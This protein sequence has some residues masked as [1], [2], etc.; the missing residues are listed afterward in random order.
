MYN[1]DMAT[2]RF[3]HFS[4]NIVHFKKCFLFS[5]HA[6]SGLYVSQNLESIVSL[7][8]V[9]I[10]SFTLYFYVSFCLLFAYK[11]V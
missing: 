8:R 7:T 2:I 6:I 11:R 3:L 9:I 10:S 5:N 4:V 1:N